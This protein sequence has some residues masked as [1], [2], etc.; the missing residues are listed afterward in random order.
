M[1]HQLR[2]Y[3]VAVILV[4]SGAAAL[5]LR[6]PARRARSAAASSA[7]ATGQST[8]RWSDRQWLVGRQYVHHVRVTSHVGDANAAAPSPLM[9]FSGR[10][11]ST[12][13]DTDAD[14]ALVALHLDEVA[15]ADVAMPPLPAGDAKALSVDVFAQFDGQGR[16]RALWVPADLARGALTVWRE[17]VSTLQFATPDRDRAAWSAV[18]EDPTGEFA[19]DYRATADPHRFE[20]SKR[21]YWRLATREGLTSP[22]DM[23]VWSEKSSMVYTL[24]DDHIARSVASLN[25]TRID[26]P[27]FDRSFRSRTEASLTFA[28]QRTVTA[29]RSRP[30]DYRRTTIYADAAS[31]S[32]GRNVVADEPVRS[33]DELLAGIGRASQAGGAEEAALVAELERV[34][35]TTPS[36][37]GEAVRR[38]D[39]R[40]G[41][42]VL[43]ALGRVQ[44]PEAQRAICT[45][46]SDGHASSELRRTAAMTL[47]NLR[48][49][50]DATVDALRA[51]LA[52]ESDASVL[53]P[54]SFALGVAAQ[55]LRTSSPE[56]AAKLVNELAT[57][58]QPSADAD[59]QVRALFSLGNTRHPDAIPYISRAFESSD[60]RVRG[61]AAMALRSM[62]EGAA[63]ALLTS[64]AKGDGDGS[65][66]SIALTALDNRPPERLLPFFQSVTRTE[67]DPQV[68]TTAVGVVSH[69]FHDKANTDARA[70]LEWVAI[71]DQDASV[72]QQARTALASGHSG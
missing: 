25:E 2:T 35:T 58:L 7:E 30:S 32:G 55:N 36:A 66:R 14:G 20:K 27:S 72:R 1:R 33:L 59:T 6:G 31:L 16:A 61:T 68:R 62:D 24:G 34:F 47:S 17:L 23:T 4:C 56:L 49:P 21:V 44:T 71:H 45:V 37:A 50:T 13:V 22:R 48:A 28:G 54:A 39:A 42:A 11:Q 46:L 18:E 38:L 41:P 57:G 12:V 60:P 52:R 69:W 9:G 43:R 5:W 10:L 53:R 51:L 64:V 67:A 26:V 70:V 40:T 8:G 65:V 15:A 29:L 63:E 3:V 19:A